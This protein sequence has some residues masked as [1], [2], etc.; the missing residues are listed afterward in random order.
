MEWARPLGTYN[1][2]TVLDTIDAI[3][4]VMVSPGVTAHTESTRNVD[5]CDLWNTS[6]LT[7]SWTSPPSKQPSHPCCMSL[8]C[9]VSESAL[10]V[11]CLGQ[12]RGTVV[13]IDKPRRLFLH[14]HV[15]HVGEA[16]QRI[17]LF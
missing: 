12:N 15:D 8:E 7:S 4:N 14:Y 16:G 6:V 17:G 3:I 13:G 11:V 2:F 5:M 1:R 9:V 10:P